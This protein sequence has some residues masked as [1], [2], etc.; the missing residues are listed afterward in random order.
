ML[1]REMTIVIPCHVTNNTVLNLQKYSG[2]NTPFGAIT[3]LGTSTPSGDIDMKKIGQA[4]NTL[5]DI[6]LT[7]VREPI[8]NYLLVFVM[9]YT[10]HK[11]FAKD[12]LCL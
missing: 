3:P 4:R 12:G 6:K 5:M 9:H 8:T 11:R 2:L 7:Q 1:G 10:N